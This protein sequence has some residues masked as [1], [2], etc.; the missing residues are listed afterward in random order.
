MKNNKLLF[1]GTILFVSLWSFTIKAQ[2]AV[3]P[4]FT[5]VTTKHK[6]L[7]KSELELQKVEQ[8]YYDKVTSKNDL[9]IGTEVLHHLYTTDNSEILFVTLYKTWGDIEEATAIT[10]AL[11]EKAWPN[12]KERKAFM[13][14]K[15]SFYTSYHSDEILKSQPWVGQKNLNTDSQE[16]IV[17]YLRTSQLANTNQGEGQWDALNEYNDKVTMKNPYVLGYYPNRHYWGSDSRDFHEAFLY[18]SLSDME[19][20]NTEMTALIEAAWPN[21]K[22]RKEF[23]DTMNK[24]FTGIHGDY[25]YRNE[26]TMRK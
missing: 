22:E 7:N 14:K 25:I 24:E 9:I 18:N 26:P 23:M 10:Q 4:I 5:I 13:D 6:N 3:D 12:E 2:E 1:F 19:A 21:E 20:A 16:S 11:I 17:V 15:D 8:E